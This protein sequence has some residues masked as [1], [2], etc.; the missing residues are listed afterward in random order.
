MPAAMTSTYSPPRTRSWTRKLGKAAVPSSHR[1]TSVETKDP[2]RSPYALRNSAP[3]IEPRLVPKNTRRGRSASVEIVLPPRRTRLSRKAS[4]NPTHRLTMLTPTTRPT[5]RKADAVAGDSPT[6]LSATTKR[7]RGSAVSGPAPTKK[8]PQTM[9]KSDK[10]S[11]LP[12]V[13]PWPVPRVK[14][15]KKKSIPSVTSAVD[16]I[17]SSP[18]HPS[19][20]HGDHRKSKVVSSAKINGL[21]ASTTTNKEDSP[22]IQSNGRES[23]DNSNGKGSS[24]LDVT[25]CSSVELSQLNSRSNSVAAVPKSLAAV[26]FKSSAN[27][28]VSLTPSGPPPTILPKAPAVTPTPDIT[29]SLEWGS[30]ANYDLSYWNS[31]AD[32]T[33]LGYFDYPMPDLLTNGPPVGEFPKSGTEDVGV[34][35]STSTPLTGDI[36]AS[37]PD[38]SGNV[39]GGGPFTP[40][41]TIFSP[42][43][44]LLRRVSQPNMMGY[45]GAVSVTDPMAS[46]SSTSSTATSSS[47]GLVPMTGLTSTSSDTEDNSSDASALNPQQQLAQTMA[48]A[49]NNWVM[50][51]MLSNAMTSPLDGFTSFTTRPSTSGNETSSSLMTLLPLQYPGFIPGTSALSDQ[52]VSLPDRH[53][54]NSDDVATLETTATETSDEEA[55]YYDDDE[56]D[57]DEITELDPYSFIATLPPLPQEQR[58]RPFLLPRKTRSSPPITLVLDLDETLVH[59]T[60]DGVVNPDLV[61]PVEVNSSVHQVFC[62]LRPGFREFLERVSKSFEVVIFTASM[63]V[64]ADRLLNIIDPGRHLIR[65]RLFREACVKIAD[66]Y[67]K[68]LSI[69]GRDLSKVVIVDNSPQVFGYQLSNGIPIESWYNDPMDSELC[70]VTEFLESLLEVD[71]VR[72]HIEKKYR[73]KEK[74]DRASALFVSP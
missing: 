49:A 57:P 71:D 45:S 38:M 66:A 14:Q 65:H 16:F 26:A 34:E 4:D 22:V 43:F 35:Q 41:K 63:K 20:K 3:V 25:Q 10:S 30:L 29:S 18:R 68:D 24:T 13:Q 48:T 12:V 11:A 47:T 44:N 54:S 53:N 17:T 60:T 40:F 50:F 37:T 74:V 1:T 59:C 7:H 33:A 27:A 46:A 72:P 6:S 56:D 58:N 42:V 19:G 31:V 51:P 2:F 73:L 55:A 28:T 15:A 32:P 64:Y 21:S 8:I 5:K 61:F 70:A 62:R 67:M 36:H 52:S 9:A 23:T 69:L 39:S